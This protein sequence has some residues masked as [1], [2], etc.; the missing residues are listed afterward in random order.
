MPLRVSISIWR[1]RY[2]KISH[3]EPPAIGVYEYPVRVYRTQVHGTAVK[4]ARSVLVPEVETKWKVIGGCFE[5][6]GNREGL[7]KL[8][9][10]AEKKGANN[11]AFATLF[12]LGD[13]KPCVDLLVQT[14]RAPEA[15]LF[16]RA[17]A[18]SLGVLN[19]VQVE[20]KDAD[21]MLFNVRRPC[22]VEGSDPEQYPG[23]TRGDGQDDGSKKWRRGQ[24][25][26]LQ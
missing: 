22:C 7:Q 26:T 19:T 10:T 4:I 11:L 12:Q 17:Y 9:A 2:T 15:A 3:S 24:A 18:P 6:A 25:A 23:G 14:N 16:A 13:A 21:V 8:A 20:L 5:C 1:Q